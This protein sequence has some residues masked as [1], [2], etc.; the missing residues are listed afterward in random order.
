MKPADPAAFAGA[1][2]ASGGVDA[3]LA[4]AL[5][6]VLVALTASLGDLAY[7]LGSDADTLRRHMTSLQAVDHITQ[8]Q[9]AIAEILRSSASMADRISA[10]TLEGLAERLRAGY[11]DHADCA[12][13]S[14]NAG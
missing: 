1:A 3:P 7:D 8:S 13:M 4:L 2:D 6:D 12:E 10:V 11:E 9:L 14:C 5:A